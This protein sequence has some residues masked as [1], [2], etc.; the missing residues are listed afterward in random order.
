MDIIHIHIE[1]PY[2]TCR[3]ITLFIIY[4]VLQKQRVST[5]HMAA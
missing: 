1:E 5:I 2:I 4:C 3:V